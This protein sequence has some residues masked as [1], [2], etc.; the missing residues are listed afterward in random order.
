MKKTKKSTNGTSFHDTVLNATVNQL[1]S[2]L[3]EPTFKE[4]TGEDKVNFE[5]DLENESGMTFT[6]YD[7]KEYRPIG[8]DEMI[9]WHLGGHAKWSAEMG[10]M[11]IETALKSVT[12]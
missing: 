11:E 3:G 5:W 12:A 2:I 7:W 10:K 1:T 6:V 8:L 4:N 9:E